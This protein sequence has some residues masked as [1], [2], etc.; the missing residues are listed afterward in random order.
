MSS[1]RKFSPEFKAEVVELVIS[2]DRP[3]VPVAKEISISD[4]SLG[5]LVREWKEE[6]PEAGAKDPG[7]VERSHYK[8]LQAENSELKREIEFRESQC[9]LRREVTIDEY[10]AFI[11]QEKRTTPLTVCASY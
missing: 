8:A 6:H 7:P 4:G 11:G 3:T 10:Y 2:S 1:R 9:L 5:N